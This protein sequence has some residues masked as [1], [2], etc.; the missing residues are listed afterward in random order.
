MPKI[1]GWSS[2]LPESGL[3]GGCV[4]D[5]LSPTLLSGPRCRGLRQGA[6]AAAF[7]PAVPI[8]MRHPATA[9]SFSAA[10]EAQSHKAEH[11][12]Q[13][14][15][16]DLQQLGSDDSAQAATARTLV[17]LS[18]PISLLSGCLC[19]GAA[20]MEVRCGQF[21]FQKANL[22]EEDMA[23]RPRTRPESE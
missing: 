14:S 23:Q 17:Y 22:I 7:L 5:A 12:T 18:V 19:A 8:D 2:L 6:A 3:P 4:A 16:H 15:L 11:A 9:S 13:H 21:L 1:A 10:G 20:Y